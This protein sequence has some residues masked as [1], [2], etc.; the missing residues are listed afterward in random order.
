MFCIFG[1]LFSPRGVGFYFGSHLPILDLPRIFIGILIL[2]WLIKKI[3]KKEPFSFGWSSPTLFLILLI[4]FQFVSIFVSQVKIIS[5]TQWVGFIV[6]YYAIYFIILDQIKNFDDCNKIVDVL[7]FV[8]ICL[9]ALS[10]YEGFSGHRVYEEAR[11]AWNANPFAHFKKSINRGGAPSSYGPY[12]NPHDLG[13]FFASTFFLIIYKFVK[14]K[15]TW[16]KIMTS[17]LVFILILGLFATNTRGAVLAVFITLLFALM[18]IKRK[19]R[20]KLL[21]ISLCLLLVGI[22]VFSFF[23]PDRMGVEYF[24]LWYFKHL[25]GHGGYATSGIG[26]RIYA[27]K[28]NLPLMREKPF[29]GFGMGSFSK[30]KW[31][32]SPIDVGP[33]LN[34]YCGIMLE[35]G[36]FAAVMFI[37]LI[38]SSFFKLMFTYRRQKD[39]LEAWLSF[40]V[41]LSILCYSIAHFTGAPL[42]SSFTF[43]ILLALAQRIKTA[44]VNLPKS[45]KVVKEYKV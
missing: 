12:G 38:I 30:S 43:F 40:S 36:I 8:T 4:F 10:L 22:I 20:L 27:I 32:P 31:V 26:G 42:D 21:Y 13:L 19:Y 15:K 17:V 16:G 28:C 3:V 29:L 33:D 41:L 5:F 39:R 2:S 14:E 34:I 44:K 45:G 23:A 11:T 7:I 18:V 35:S 25:W 9:A 6:C 1:I 37:L 24:T